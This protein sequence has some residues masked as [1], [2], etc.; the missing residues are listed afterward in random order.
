LR[1]AIRRPALAQKPSSS[2]FQ[3]VIHLPCERGDVDAGF[4]TIIVSVMVVR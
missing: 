3:S 1:R 2:G 4:A